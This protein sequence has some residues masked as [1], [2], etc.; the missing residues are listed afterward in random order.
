M[1]VYGTTRRQQ[2]FWRA[3]PVACAAALAAGLLFA[4]GDAQAQRSGYAL[5]FDGDS[6]I[7]TDVDAGD[8]G[9]DGNAAKSIEAWAYTRSFNSGGIFFLGNTGSDG[10]DFSLRTLTDANWWRV[11]FWGGAF[12][13]DFE[14]PS[15][16]TWVHFALV[17]TGSETIVYADGAQIA[18]EDRELDTS[19]EQPFRIGVWGWED[20][21]PWDIYDGMIAEV[22]V[23]NRAIDAAEIQANMNRSLTGDEDGLIGYWPLNEGSGDV[24]EDWAQ[25]NDGSFS[26]NLEWVFEWP[27]V[28]DLVSQIVSMGQNVTLG[29]VEVYGAED[30]TYTWFKDGEEIAGAD[31]AAYTISDAQAEDSGTYH[32]EVD[33]ARDDTP[34]ESAHVSVD[35]W[36]NLPGASVLSLGL[37]GAALAGGAAWTL[38]RRRA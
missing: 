21:A 9:I 29:P 5:D 32:V 11:Q 23:W 19:T 35:V 30:E 3:V 13:I 16:N 33:D 4:A 37:L 27:F 14:Y 12:D 20:G 28:T 25:G 15:E 1:K 2:W 17:H 34:V 26:G 31:E 36:E 18:R 38:R 10:I 6:W 7:E 22:R 8:L 24:A